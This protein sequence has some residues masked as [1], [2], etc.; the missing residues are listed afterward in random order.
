M[1]AFPTSR[2][3]VVS[4]VFAILF[5]LFTLR[6]PSGW[7][8]DPQG[9]VL[10]PSGTYV[11]GGPSPEAI[12]EVRQT[13]LANRP[14]CSGLTKGF[15]DCMPKH[16]VKIRSFWMDITEVTNREFA[17]FVEATG[18]KTIA[19]RELNPAD[20]PQVPIDQLKSGS[21]V[22]TPPKKA[23]SLF[24]FMEWWSYVPGACWNHPEGPRSTIANLM[25]YPAVHIAYADAEAFAKWAGKRLPSEAEWEWAARG[26]LEEQAYPWGNQLLIDG[27]WQCNAYQG[28]FPHLDLAA[29]G[30]KGMAPVGQFKPNKYGLMDMSGNVWEWC[31]DFYHPD[32][33]RNRKEL[34]KVLENPKGPISSWDPEEP[35]IIKRVHRGGSFLCSSEYCARYMIGTRG[36]G[37]IDTGASHVGFRCVKELP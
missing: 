24:N 20:F 2:P 37:D 5:L 29:D 15:E 27:K 12:L 13:N 17:K 34:G 18:Y 4:I 11:M 21:V 30:F 16:Q 1:H 3:P 6:T 19:E 7:C 28:E 33:Y 35:G 31:S 32:T 8:E 26:G 10:V 22:F 14:C 25:D 23:V 9:M 36:K